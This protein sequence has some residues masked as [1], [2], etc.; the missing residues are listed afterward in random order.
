MFNRKTDSSSYVNRPE[1]WLP[2]HLRARFSDAADIRESLSPLTAR[3]W[4]E[5]LEQESVIGRTRVEVDLALPYLQEKGEP[6]DRET[7]R[8]LADE[9]L[10]D[11]A[12]SWSAYVTIRSREH[13]EQLLTTEKAAA[14]R[15]QRR[16]QICKCPVCG[17]FADESPI[18]SVQARSLPS[19]SE[20]LRSCEACHGVAVRALNERFDVERVSDGRT[21]RAT[22]EAY[23]AISATPPVPPRSP[24]RKRAP[25][26]QSRT[27]VP[28]LVPSVGPEQRYLGTVREG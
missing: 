5:F 28:N 6:I 25:E 26:R 12:R 3:G 11:P 20:R 15:E 9:I 8:N 2:Q 14:E 21:R 24:E 18:G 27:I 23:L 7:A 4:Q 22:V 16:I 19:R 13:L 10:R 1:L 17:Q